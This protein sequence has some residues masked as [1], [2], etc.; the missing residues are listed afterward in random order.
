M[1][2]CFIYGLQVTTEVAS[3]RYKR[4]GVADSFWRVHKIIL[5]DNLWS[6]SFFFKKRSLYSKKKRLLGIGNCMYKFIKILKQITYLEQWDIFSLGNLVWR[7]CWKIKQFV[8]SPYT[9]ISILCSLFN[10]K[11]SVSSPGQVKFLL[12]HLTPGVINL[13]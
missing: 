4:E 9:F 12:V 13:F 10:L 3:R 1:G 5:R 11:E 2:E 7:G 8:M 6:E